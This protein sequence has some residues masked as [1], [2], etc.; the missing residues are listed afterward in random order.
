MHIQTS[1]ASAS[2]HC[3]V[4]AATLRARGTEDSCPCSANG[5]FL[6]AQF[7]YLAGLELLDLC[8]LPSQEAYLSS[9]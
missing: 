1:A 8:H 3:R 9:S 7:G 5:E 2:R 4:P 6:Y